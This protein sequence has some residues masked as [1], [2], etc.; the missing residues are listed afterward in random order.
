MHMSH[1]PAIFEVV[2]HSKVVGGVAQWL[3][4]WTGDWLV[5]FTCP[6]SDLW[7]TGGHFVGK[8]VH[9]G[10]SYSAYSDFHPSGVGISYNLGVQGCRPLNR[11]MCGA[12]LQARVPW[13]WPWAAAYAELWLF[14]MHSAAKVTYAACNTRYMWTLP[15]L[16]IY[17]PRYFIMDFWEENALR[18]CWVHYKVVIV[19]FTRL[20]VFVLCCKICHFLLL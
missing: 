1:D 2:F 15:F 6:E 19:L 12:W 18:C 5:D 8:A 7:L 13:A 11:T 17:W 14:L 16:K 10:F 20:C 9:Y 4:W 3:R